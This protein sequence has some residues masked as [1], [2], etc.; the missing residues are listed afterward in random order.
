MSS[1]CGT[2]WTT[3]AAAA[4]A[5]SLA[6]CA[7]GPD[8]K[9][10]QTQAPAAWS[11]PLEA[12][13]KAGPA[14]LRKWWTTLGDPALDSL[15][16][17]AV[18]GSL[19]L[20]EAAARVR[21]ARAQRGVAASELWPEVDVTGSYSRSRASENGAFVG[22][23]G[24]GGAPVAGRNE[25]TDL[26]QA[27]FDASWEIDVF[28]RVRRSVEAADADIGAAT[29][30]HRDV[31]VTLLA[32]VARNYVELRTFQSRLEIAQQNVKV[33]QATVDLSR[34]RY[35][36]GLTSELDVA[37]S[38]SQ[39]A[40]TQ[41]QIPVLDTG[42]KTAAHRLG[43][44]LGQQPGALLG[45]LAASKPIPPAP[46]EAG[47]GGGG[48]GG[49]V[50]VGLP[51]DL[52]RRRPDIRRAER[53][54][55]AATARIGMATADLFPRFSLTGSFGFQSTQV[56]DLV[57]G[58]SRF[59]SIG[60]AV[61]WPIFEAG[62]IRS[63]INVQGARQEQ[64]AARYER[65]V[66]TAFEDVENALVAYSRQQARRAS[67]EQAV[68]ADLRAVDLANELYTRDL[69]D[70]LNVLDSQRQLFLLQDQLVESQGTVTTSLIALYKALGG[71]WD[72]PSPQ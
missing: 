17:R 40:T 60:P 46:G 28:G 53:D 18:A 15:I 5:L 7:V 34:S 11:E 42:V 61:R 27:G 39:L 8:Y 13:V 67:L 64:A 43:V 41:S 19:D 29:E 25:A 10:P 48:G 33:Q 44:L 72:E 47:G 45:E 32:E 12:G 63:N 21:E 69:T 49:G 22:G 1:R 71:G 50:P 59:W 2:G 20:R 9:A 36:A 6:G 31:L 30:A 37:R 56:G 52:L 70:F 14:D 68:A 65:T 51:S 58:D 38:E 23:S 4:A 62:R 26:Y 35:E 57:D 16:E 24:G 55:A 3:G 66:L 54:L